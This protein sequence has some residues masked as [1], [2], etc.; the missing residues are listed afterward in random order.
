MIGFFV[1][2]EVIN[3]VIN[4][5]VFVYVKVVVCDIKNYIKVIIKCW[6]GVGYVVND[7]VDI[8]ENIVKYFNCGN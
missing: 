5:D 3:N 7:D 4:I 2:N 1:G 6:L 8:C